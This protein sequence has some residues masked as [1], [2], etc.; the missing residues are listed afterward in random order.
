MKSIEQ[1]GSNPQYEE[2]VERLEGLVAQILQASAIENVM[3]NGFDRI[4]AQ[5]EPLRDLAPKRT[6]LSEA[7]SEQLRQLRDSL[8]R[9]KWIG[10]DFRVQPG[11]DF[12]SKGSVAL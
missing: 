6:L 2:R 9:P 5:L 10:S 12:D 11:P 4:S 1:R 7:A 8:K 3:M